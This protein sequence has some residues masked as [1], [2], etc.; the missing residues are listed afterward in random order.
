MNAKN[1]ITIFMASDTEAPTGYRPQACDGKGEGCK[2]NT[3]R[4][5]KASCKNC[6]GAHDGETIAQLIQ[7][8]EK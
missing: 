3:F 4:A 7:R 8:V 2:R 6:V 1:D 5:T